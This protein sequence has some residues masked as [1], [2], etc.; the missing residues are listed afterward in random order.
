M[1]AKRRHLLAVAD[2]LSAG[3]LPVLLEPTAR[4]APFVRCSPDRRQVAVVLMNLALDPTGPLTLRLRAAPK[5]LAILTAQGE[6][7]L[8]LRPAGAELKVD[9]PSIPAWHTAVLVS[10]G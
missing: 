4:V 3:Q 7:E 10:A 8:L 9:V 2:W 6:Q 5:R 1:G